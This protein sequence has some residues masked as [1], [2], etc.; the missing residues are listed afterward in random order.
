MKMLRWG[1]LAAVMMLA[2]CDKVPAGNVGVKVYLLGGDKGVDTEEL[3]PGRYWLTWNEEL[4]L[5]PTF[6]QNYTWMYE[7]IDDN[8]DGKRQLSETQDESITFQ[9][10]EGLNVS[11]DVGITYNV[12]PTK[13]SVLFQK[14]RK[15]L[16]E[17]TDGYLRNMVRDALVQ[18]ASTRPIETVYG[19]GKADLI[20]ATEKRVR[21]QVEPFGIRVE[22]LYW[23]GQLRLPQTVVASIDAK[24]KAT[25]FAQ[26]RANEVAAAKAEADKAVES[27]RGE[28]ESRLIVA[29]AEA[30][31]IRIKGD[32][33]RENPRL[34]ELSAIEKWNGVLPTFNGGGAVPFVNVPS[35][36]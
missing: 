32:A 9:T 5:F 25:Q 8:E 1:V 27:A 13:V 7:W 17:I 12:D 10:I 3:S 24:I 26:Q 28:A 16:P 34:V 2:A 20:A 18:E 15:G 14:F 23:A 29:K 19:Q 11:A 22:R 30:D 6:A 21:D 35:G 36:K 33:L 4:Y 31:A